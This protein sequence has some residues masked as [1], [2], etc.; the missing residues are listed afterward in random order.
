MPE[1]EATGEI[2]AESLI[3][4][5]RKNFE[6]NLQFRPIEMLLEH[7]PAERILPHLRP[8]RVYLT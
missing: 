1:K 3:E 8:D 5:G 4:I 7:V 6:K 2:T